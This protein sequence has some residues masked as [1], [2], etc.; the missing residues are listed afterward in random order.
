MCYFIFLSC[1]RAGRGVSLTWMAEESEQ[2]LVLLLFVSVY[3]FFVSVGA[4][5]QLV[6]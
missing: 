2:L 5:R 4:Q 1:V 6:Y 3:S